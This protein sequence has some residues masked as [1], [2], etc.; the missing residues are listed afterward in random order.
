[1][2]EISLQWLIPYGLLLL[3]KIAMSVLILIICMVF[4]KIS[5]GLATRFF[6]SKI[7]IGR[8]NLID[9]RKA[10]TMNSIIGSIIKYLFYFIAG[11]SILIYLG[12]P[13]TSLVAV[14]GIGSVA[15]G[16]GC[17][18]LVQ[19]LVAGFFIL[20]EDQ[21]GVGDIVTIE[22]HTGTVEAITIRTTCLRAADGTVFIIPNGSIKIVINMCKEFMNAVIDVGIDYGEDMEHVLKVLHDEMEKAAKII[23]GL[24]NTPMVLGIIA[25]DDSAVTV[26]ITAE[27]EVKENYRIERELRLLIKKRLDKEQIS[28]PFP[29]RTIHIIN[30]NQDT[31]SE[32]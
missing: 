6:N 12:V 10:E 18:G 5:K 7:G 25:L 9:S 1:M 32:K 24:R 16:L 20:L 31:A 2:T 4:I 11:C 3:Q 8:L 26:R 23:T 27:C 22:G 14:A 28:I 13:P 30:E 21:F 29:Q 17:Q 15:I 19:D